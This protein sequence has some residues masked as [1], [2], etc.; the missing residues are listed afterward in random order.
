MTTL[1]GPTSSIMNTPHSHKLLPGWPNLSI[2]SAERYL[3]G[4]SSSCSA[5][6]LKTPLF[7]HCLSAI[8]AG[9]GCGI[10]NT[11]T[12]ISDERYVYLFGTS[13]SLI[14]NQCTSVRGSKPNKYET[15]GQRQYFNRCLESNP[16]Q[17]RHYRCTLPI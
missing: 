15:Q 11:R 14:R 16:S 8:A 1:R 5:S 13:T 4:S 12:I 10:S 6:R 7:Q 2:R 9:P 3:V 17:G